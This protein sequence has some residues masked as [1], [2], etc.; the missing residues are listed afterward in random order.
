[1]LPLKDENPS[2]I[3][4]LVNYSIIVMNFAVFFLEISDPTRMSVLIND[5]GF[6]PSLLLE[7]PLTNTY[8]VIT[9]IFLHGG[10]VH[11]LGN[12]LYLF[13][14]GDNVEAAFGHLNYAFFYML[15]GVSANMVHMIVSQLIGMM[16]IPA[17]GASGAISGILG[18]YLL[19]YPRARVITLIFTWYLAALRPIPAKYFLGFWFIL[20]LIPGLLLGEN[21]GVAYWAHIGGFIVG[22]TLAFP[23]KSRADYLRYLR[24]RDTSG[25]S[26]NFS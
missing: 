16:D 10:W 11:L 21:T 4:P 23:Y 14:F 2:P 9:S 20:Q 13:I 6:I 1:M 8:R 18:A 24:A 17:V 25:A 19:L 12:M 22:I 15:S 3:R 5:Y 26:R 7:E